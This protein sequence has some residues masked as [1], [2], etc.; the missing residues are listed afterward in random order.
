LRPRILAQVAH[1]RFRAEPRPSPSRHLRASTLCFSFPSRSNLYAT[2]ARPGACPVP[3]S[4]GRA[5]CPSEGWIKSA[6]TL[7]AAALLK[8]IPRTPRRPAGARIRIR[9]AR[10]C[11]GGDGGPRVRVGE[12]HAAG[13]YGRRAAPR[14]VA[15]SRTR[16]RRRHLFGDRSMARPRQW[17]PAESRQRTSRLHSTRSWER[18]SVSAE[19]PNLGAS[20]LESRVK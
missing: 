16:R 7:G 19:T 14:L 5:G 2:A 15:Q 8:S 18:Q 6:M 11:L 20:S 13:G 9:Q 1:W 3:R 10:N 4:P 12:C 17:W